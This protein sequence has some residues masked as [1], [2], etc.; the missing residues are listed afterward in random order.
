MHACM[1]A[2]ARGMGG[3]QQ[4]A[5]IRSPLVTMLPNEAGIVPFSQLLFKNLRG[6]TGRSSD[7]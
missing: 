4:A 6:S 5:H 2:Y 7:V 3:P 1:R